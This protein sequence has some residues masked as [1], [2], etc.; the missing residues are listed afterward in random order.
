MSD[1]VVGDYGLARHG[2]RRALV[3]SERARFVALA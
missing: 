1:T 2:H 3:R